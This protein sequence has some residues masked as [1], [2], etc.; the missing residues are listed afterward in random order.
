VSQEQ[1]HHPEPSG[2]CVAP[3]VYLPESA[4]QFTAMQAGGPGG[5]HV[6]KV[7]TKMRLRVAMD[8]LA[9]V[10]DDGAMRRLTA[11]AGA[12][13]TRD[14][15]LIFTSQASRSAISN[16]RNCIELLRELLTQAKRRPRI[17]KKKRVSASAK[18]KRL[19]AKRQRSQVK[20]LRS[21]P[22]G[23]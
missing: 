11:L 5:Q 22:S 9:Q 3:G 15:D 21:R 14:G 6:N 12:R 19:E 8:D 10:L 17:R 16:R 13:L 18:R 23:D 4:L 20:R 1:P 7:A 2:V